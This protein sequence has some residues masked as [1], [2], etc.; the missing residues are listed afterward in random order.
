MTVDD[1]SS[2]T[3]IVLLGGE[4]IDV[5][6]IGPLPRA[7]LVIAA[8]SGAHYA[9]SLGLSV[10]VVI[11]DMDSIATTALEAL[12]VL[13]TR[14]VSHPSDKNESDA[15]L[16]LR[17]A[18]TH[19]PRRLVVVGSGGGRL[20]HQLSLYSLLFHHALDG[21]EVEARVAGSRS[22]PIRDGETRVIECRTNDIVG[23]LPFG[24]DAHGITTE[25]L[26]WPLR[27]ESLLVTA[28]RGVS[29]RANGETFKVMVGSGRLL[30][31]L[32]KPDRH[33]GRGQK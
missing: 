1:D 12:R 17:H 25:G 5:S 8:D 3:S 27:N 15:E 11:G 29:N 2:N 31:T 32:D 10:D 30:V 7:R 33:E 16:A 24:G 18:A 4:N 22:Y 20:D 14:I 23:L 13:G 26:Q 21:I 28:S 19:E 6:L 9:E